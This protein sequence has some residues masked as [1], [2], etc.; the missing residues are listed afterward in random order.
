MLCRFQTW[1][2]WTIKKDKDILHESKTGTENNWLMPLQP[3]PAMLQVSWAQNMYSLKPIDSQMQGITP[4]A[5]PHRFSWSF[6]QSEMLPASMSSQA[7]PEKCSHFVG[8][9]DVVCIRGKEN[10]SPGGGDLK[11]LGSSWE[12]RQLC[13]WL[14][15]PKFPVSC[16]SGWIGLMESVERQM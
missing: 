8:W 11:R 4:K 14:W 9:I 16:F 2:K 6:Q 13:Y 12:Q 10:G 15:N 7:E 5:L 3:S 1:L